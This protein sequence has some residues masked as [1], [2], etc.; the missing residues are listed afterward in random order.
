MVN[1]SKILTVS[2]GTFSCTL[3]G[4][5]DS[6]D[7]MKAI[8]EYF[9]DLAADDR[10]FGAE[11]PTPDA[12]LMARIAER[13]VARHVEAREE[14][15]KIVLRADEPAASMPT[16]ETPASETANAASFTPEP[17][18][19]PVEEAATEGALVDEL[20]AEAEEVA[21]PLEDLENEPAESVEAPEVETEPEAEPELETQV[22]VEAKTEYELD[23]SVLEVETANAEVTSDETAVAA[24][25]EDDNSVAARLRRIRSVVAKGESDLE[26]SG[27]SEDEHAQD[28][29]ADTVADIDA[30]LAADDLTDL[31]DAEPMS[32][33]GTEAS[34]DTLTEILAQDDASEEDDALEEETISIPD[35]DRDTLSQL[36]ADAVPDD[37]EAIEEP[38][39]QG[40][41]EDNDDEETLDTPLRAR[42]IKMK[43]SDFEAAMEKGQLEEEEDAL[44]VAYTEDPEL[45]KDDVP[46]GRP[47][48]RRVATSLN[49]EDEAELQK[50]LDAVAAELRNYDETG[51]AKADAEHYDD[52][53][54]YEEAPE[55]QGN[56]RETHSLRT[57]SKLLTDEDDQAMSR[58]FDD[59]QTKF[60][61]PE[62]NRRRTAI[63]HL[64]AAVEAN[65]AETNAGSKLREEASEDA[66]RS[67]IADVVR[68]SQL[69][70][71]VV[72]SSEGIARS[73]NRPRRPAEARPA[74]L[75]LV[76]EQRIDTP[77]EPVRPR[78]V[79]TAQHA[80]NDN[81]VENNEG[82]VEFA[83]E[84]GASN[85]SELLEAAAAYMSDVEGRVQFS[86]PM[87]MGKLKEATADEFSREDGLRSFGE[88][89]RNGKLQ[90][91][92]GGRFAVTDETDYRSNKRDV[93]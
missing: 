4:F 21:A 15:G 54:E 9:R 40:D 88:L 47:L 91:L 86:R 8:A 22:E 50:E 17:V 28:F 44:D 81:G 6:F 87:L 71:D 35:L 10:Y 16:L 33:G 82:F 19:E 56:P 29:L 76:A 48:P 70:D 1:N 78:R 77:R 67:D 7:T 63:R 34:V 51:E 46:E 3:E 31:E 58:L 23:L 72:P 60:A 55:W 80:D 11:P 25:D 92:K 59:A 65:T 53:T 73:R 85:L 79:S 49:A 39:L 43:R 2:Y 32:L 14:R 64:R 83:E 57:K 75:K 30:A 37:D 66:Y 42:V 24:E 13:E 89:L 62:S 5:D 18:E 84:I 74:P 12:E 38:V 27:F 90:K 20:M 45:Y 41:I 61:A 69:R 52:E 93:S 36:L 26:Q 68:P